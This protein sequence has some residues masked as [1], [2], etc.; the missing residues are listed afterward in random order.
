MKECGQGWKALSQ[1]RKY[2]RWR[3]FYHRKYKNITVIKKI[4]ILC[5]ISIQSGSIGKILL[6]QKQL[7]I[8]NASKIKSYEY[9]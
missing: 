4:D 8:I 9:N 2:A 6:P 5:N 7:K 3:N 1:D